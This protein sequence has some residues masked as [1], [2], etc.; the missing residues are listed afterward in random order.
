[1]D[2]NQLFEATSKFKSGLLA[3]ATNGDYSTS[4]YIDTLEILQSEKRLEKMLPMAIKASRTPDDFRREMQSKFAHYSDRRKF[5]NDAFEPIF[6]YLEDLR[7]GSD[8]FVNN[9]ENYELGNPI[10]RGGYG[11]VYKLRHKLLDMDFA[12]KIFDP[13]FVADEENIEGEKR[14]F[15]EAKILFS[16]NHENIVR[17]YDIGRIKGKPYM[18][19]EFVDGY[20]MQSFLEKY[21]VVDYE[22]SL[23]PITALLQGLRYAH[24]RGI[25]HR[26]LKPTNFMV[27]PEGRFIIIDFGISA[28]L[29]YDKY[30][31]LT[32]TGES[33]IGGAYSDPILL[34]NPKLRDIRNDIYSVG[35]IWYYLLV[36]VA[37]VGGDVKEKLLRTGITAA[38]AEIVLKCISSDINERYSSCEELLSVLYPVSIKAEDKPC[39]GLEREITEI[40][41]DAIFESLIERYNNEMDNFVYNVPDGYER[42]DCVFRYYGRK[43]IIEFL[44]RVYNFNLIPSNEGDFEQEMQNYLLKNGEYSYDW[45]FNEKRLQL[46]TG[47]DEILLKFLCEMFHPLVRSEKTSWDDVFLEVNTLL[48]IDGYELYEKERVSN[49]SIYGYR[50]FI[51]I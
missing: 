9:L 1:M 40:T 3:K 4:E 26:D 47:D 20:T 19:M 27:T 29:E 13:I 6:K 28:F 11:N 8:S 50:C 16:L 17:I 51:D 48:R 39:S 34:T 24:E 5:I 31:Q 37:P 18:R 23:K 42:P 44:K 12:I 33:I 35:A 45:V 32:K 46:Q 22:R 36:G 41:R 14:F 21:G 38:Q 10:G 30:T 15:R 2:V 49:K 7:N 25:I 43:G